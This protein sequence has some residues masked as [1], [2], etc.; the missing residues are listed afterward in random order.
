M[1]YLVALK[2]CTLL[3]NNLNLGELKTDNNLLEL[4]FGDWEGQAWNDI[5]QNHLNILD[6]RL[7]Q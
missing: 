2:C 6:A 5:N 4:D 3:A 1:W 7:C